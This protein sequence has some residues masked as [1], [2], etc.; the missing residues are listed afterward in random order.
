VTGPLR[1]PVVLVG[2]I[3]L[4][5]HCAFTWEEPVGGGQRVARVRSTHCAE[6]IGELGKL[7]YLML[8]EDPSKSEGPGRG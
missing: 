6:C 1:P 4:R 2:L 3:R 8:R 7:G 5:D